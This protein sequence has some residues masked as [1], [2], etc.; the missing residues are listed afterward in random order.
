MED[1]Q[2]CPIGIQTFNRHMTDIT[3]LLY[4]AEYI[5]I[6]DYDGN[7]ELY[8]FDIPNKEIRIG[9]MGSLL[10][11]N[12]NRSADANT[13]GTLTWGWIKKGNM[14]E[15]LKLLQRIA[16]NLYVVELDLDS[17]KGTIEDWKIEI[18]SDEKE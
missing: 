13:T 3:P 9:L 2:R 16:M 5:T 10:P 6:T 1:Q 7:M 8:M 15:A 18:Q 17:T 11:D 12:A 4:Q 14:D